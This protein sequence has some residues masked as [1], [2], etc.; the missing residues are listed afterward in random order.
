MEEIERAEPWRSLNTRDAH[1]LGNQTIADLDGW[2][3]LMIAAKREGLNAPTK[4]TL[5]PVE[6][7][8]AKPLEP[9]CKSTC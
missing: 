6:R 5:V 3:D 4:I 8:M 1:F 2:V 9:S 7:E